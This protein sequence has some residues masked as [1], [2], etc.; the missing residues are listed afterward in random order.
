MDNAYCNVHGSVA[1]KKFLWKNEKKPCFDSKKMLNQE[2]KMNRRTKGGT[3]KLKREKM[4]NLQKVWNGWIFQQ[5]VDG[6]V[7]T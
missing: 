4:K 7:V 1:S 3:M 5:K 2:K 6:G